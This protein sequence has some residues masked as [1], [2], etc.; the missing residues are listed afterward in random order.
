MRRWFTLSLV[1]FYQSGLQARKYGWAVIEESSAG[2]TAEFSSPLHRLWM[3]FHLLEQPLDDRFKT[4][5]LVQFLRPPFYV[6]S[7]CYLPPSRTGK[8]NFIAQAY[9]LTNGRGIWLSPEY[10]TDLGI[11]RRGSID[12][13]VGEKRWA[14]DILRDGD[15]VEDHLRRFNTPGVYHHW[16]QTGAIT[17]YIIL[18]FRIN[19]AKKNY[20]GANEYYRVIF[21]DDYSGFD[22]IDCNYNIVSTNSLL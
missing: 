1:P 18:D 14:I 21:K 11:P 17:D 15:K 2:W 22:L 9:A 16:I 10:G 12:F 3:S 8:P 19:Q 6:L 20:P 4:M 7:I 13:H 5:T